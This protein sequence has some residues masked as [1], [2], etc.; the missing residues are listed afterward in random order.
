MVCINSQWSM[1]RIFTAF[2]AFNLFS[3]FI[4]FDGPCDGDNTLCLDPVFRL[5]LPIRSRDFGEKNSVV[6]DQN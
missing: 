1:L 5:N 6:R 2:S 4:T 3:H